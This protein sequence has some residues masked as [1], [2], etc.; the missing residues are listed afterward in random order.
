MDA[1]IMTIWKDIH[2]VFNN[3]KLDIVE[4]HSSFIALEDI[5]YEIMDYDTG[6]VK[7]AQIRKNLHNYI[8]KYFYLIAEVSSAESMLTTFKA[9]N[10]SISN[11]MMTY[12][13]EEEYERAANLK[14]VLD[15]L[16]NQKNKWLPNVK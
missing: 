2:E 5:I 15:I 12:V 10:K 13:A 11:L 4:K 1:P 6:E 9:L 8:D 7:T 3:S 14:G 16:Q